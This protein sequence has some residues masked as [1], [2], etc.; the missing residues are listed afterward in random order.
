M[1]AAL[2]ATQFSIT[3]YL[4]LYLVDQFGWRSNAAA[5]VLLF[6]HLGGIAGRMAWGWI[7][8]RLVGGDRVRPLMALT[9]TGMVPVVAIAGMSL[10]RS[11]MPVAV[12]VV[13]LGAGLTA[14]GWNGLYITLV[15][16]L[17]GAGS[18]TMLGLSMSMLYFS[19]ML[20]PP[21]FG[22]L[23]ECLGSYPM[24][25]LVLVGCQLAAIGALLVVKCAVVGEGKV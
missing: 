22:Q 9:V 5:R 7:S 16:E 15:L 14:L 19:T 12:G 6:V 20:S 2:A 13:A 24:A 4:P 8:D 23:I 10:W 3:G 18:A 21:A 11:V 17:A 25:W 1:A